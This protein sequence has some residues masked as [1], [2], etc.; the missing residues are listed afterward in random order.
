MAVAKG[1]IK[2]T[3]VLDGEAA[4]YA[5]MSKLK[6]QQQ[7]LRAEGRALASTYDDETKAQEKLID[8]SKLLE[9][10]IKTQQQMCAKLHN[11][12]EDTAKATGENSEETKKAEMQYNNAVATLNNLEK[13]LNAVNQ[14]LKE[15]NSKWLAAG[16]SASQYGDML[17]NAGFEHIGNRNI[18]TN[19]LRFK[20]CKKTNRTC[21]H[22][23]QIIAHINLCTRKSM[24]ADGKRLNQGKLLSGKSFAVNNFFYRHS[25]IFLKTAVTLNTH[26]LIIRTGIN[27]SASA[28]ITFT[29]VKI[30][31]A[32]YNIT[33]FQS[34][35]IFGNFNNPSRK[36]V[37]GNSQISC[38]RLITRKRSNIGA[39]YAAVEHF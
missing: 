38:K 19:C 23:K 25:D 24:I 32:G 17:T 5:K 9:K 26:R 15:S 31:I 10:Q 36:F 12:M 13:Q 33:L 20:Q 34:S 14:E 11:E 35:V 7:A 21:T 6:V 39:A 37:T 8:K 16:K 2:T 18:R 28:G 29:A 3:L 1:N 27:N 30:G 22:N 4:F